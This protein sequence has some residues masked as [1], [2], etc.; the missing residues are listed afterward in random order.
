M[1]LF[2]QKSKL[3]N[4]FKENEAPGALDSVPFA[5]NKLDYLKF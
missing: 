1:L 5:E 3:Q 4:Q 2:P